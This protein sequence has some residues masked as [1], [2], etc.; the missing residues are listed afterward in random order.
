[1]LKVGSHAPHFSSPA[2]DGSVVSL[3]ALAGR[4]AVIYFFHKAFTPNCTN[5]LK[6]F[7]DNYDDLRRLGFEVIGI[8]TDTLATQCEFAVRYAVSH[9]M[10]GDPSRVIA[11]RYDV[12]W[13]LLPLARRVAYILDEEH[14]IVAAF[15]HEFQVSRHLDEILTFART[16]KRGREHVEQKPL[17]SLAG[18]KPREA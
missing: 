15:R 4:S 11:A 5:E 8:S 10:V 6:G 9:P 7:R 18:R 14:R 2:S 12:L 3:A 17:L 16:W 1:M 13:P